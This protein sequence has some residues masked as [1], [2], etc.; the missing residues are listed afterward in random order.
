VP[1]GTGETFKVTIEK[2]PSGLSY[3]RESIIAAEKIESLKTGKLYIMYSG[4]VDSEYA[5]SI[6]KELGIDFTPVI[7]KFKNN[8]NEHD[9]TYAEDFCKLKNLKPLIVDLDFDN[10][11]T[12]GQLLAITKEI[13]SSIYHRA[14]TAHVIANLNGTVICGDG[15]PYIR[16]NEG[17]NNW[18]VKIFQH[19]LAVS[20]YYL[21]KGINGTPFFNGYTAEMM[22][23]FLQDIRIQSLAKNSIPGKLGSDS[24]KYFVYN[25]DSYF[26]ILKR[27]KYHGYEKIESL[28]IFNHD[29]FQEIKEIGKEWDGSWA[30]EYFS[31]LSR[32]CIQ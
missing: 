13:K 30:E 15:E 11:V 22:R 4:G 25:R 17:T 28:P 12:S 21:S 14:A 2:L 9:V 19:D 3:Y 24:S 6:F 27:P 7:I 10:F 5:V 32:S 20:N 8:Y 26:N 1:S 18:E 29:A 31:F 16:L 23:S